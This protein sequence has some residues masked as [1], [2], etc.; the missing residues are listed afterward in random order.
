[1]LWEKYTYIH[2]YIFASLKCLL[3]TLKEQN[4][5]KQYFEPLL[6]W[7][8]SNDPRNLGTQYQETSVPGQCPRQHGM[9]SAQSLAGQCSNVTTLPL[10]A[11]AQIIIAESWLAW[12]SLIETGKKRLLLS[13][14]A[15]PWECW[16]FTPV[17]EF[18]DFNAKVITT[19]DCKCPHNARKR[20]NW[21]RG[22]K[23][24][25]QVNSLK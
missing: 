17:F 21:K 16:I 3:H 22:Y 14:I 10:F 1:M 9:S 8:F 23:Q 7:H 13:S 4:N 15:L 11:H 19:T 25:V 6:I 24:K 2:I 18:I 5:K 12:R 20:Y